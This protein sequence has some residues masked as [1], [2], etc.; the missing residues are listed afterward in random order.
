MGKVTPYFTNDSHGFSLMNL[1]AVPNEWIFAT[2]HSVREG[3][4]DHL[5][6]HELLGGRN[7]TVEFPLSFRDKSLR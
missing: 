5:I 4:E 2:T 1:G 3:M 6:T 7:G